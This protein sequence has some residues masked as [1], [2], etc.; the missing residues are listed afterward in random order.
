M[1][2]AYFLLKWKQQLCLMESVPYI[3][4]SSTEESSNFKVARGCFFAF[5][6]EIA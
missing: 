5:F 2:A 3:N 6:S 1:T 4:K